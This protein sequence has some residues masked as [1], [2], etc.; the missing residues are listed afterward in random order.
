MRR[1]HLTTDPR[2]QVV[3]DT[4]LSFFLAYHPLADVRDIQLRARLLEAR[5]V[6]LQGEHFTIFSDNTHKGA[7]RCVFSHFEHL[8]LNVTLLTSA[9]DA[10]GAKGCGEAP[11]ALRGRTPRMASLTLDTETAFSNFFLE[12]RD[13][14]FARVRAAAE[15][16]ISKTAATV[17]GLMSIYPHWNSML[18]AHLKKPLLTMFLMSVLE[19]HAVHIIPP[20]Q[21]TDWHETLRTLQNR[22]DAI[23]IVASAALQS[24]FRHLGLDLSKFPAVQ[25]VARASGQSPT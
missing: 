22:S 2:L 9:K 18:F 25:L 24:E 11:Y 6:N 1:I 13:V 20:S 7:L 15:R 12:V 16:E 10:Q 21:F 19:E 4:V 14:P 23:S 8:A 5:K 17:D 3:Y